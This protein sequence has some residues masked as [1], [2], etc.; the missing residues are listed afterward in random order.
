MIRDNTRSMCVEQNHLRSTIILVYLKI[1]ERSVINM[2]RARMLMKVLLLAIFLSPVVAQNGNVPVF[3]DSKWFVFKP[4]PSPSP[5]MYIGLAQNYCLNATTPLNCAMGVNPPPTFYDW[6][7]NTGWAADL[8]LLPTGARWIWAPNITPTTSPAA[9]EEFTFET[10][11]YVCD[12]PVGGTISLASDNSAEVSI[13]GTSIAGSSSTSADQLTTFSIPASVLLGS[14]ITLGARPNHIKV[15]A[16]N[17]SG[18][19]QDNYQC[20]P[21]AIVL[22]GKFEFMG[23][24][25]CNGFSGTFKTGAAETLASCPAGQSGSGTTRICVCGTWLPPT[26]I[27]MTAPPKCTGKNGQL[28]NVDAVETQSCPTGQIASPSSHRCQSNGT[29]DVPL[30]TCMTP[31]PP[32]TCAGA[33]GPFA[34][35]AMETIACPTGQVASPPRTHTCMANGQ[36]GPTTGGVCTL[37]TLGAGAM[38]AR[39]RGSVVIGNCPSGTSCGSRRSTAGNRSVWCAIFGIDCPVRLQ[40]TDWFCDPG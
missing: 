39:D 9:L 25:E 2:K 13:N 1:E 35:G 31:P 11:F 28:F 12:P 32:V 19:A 10:D 30:G 40:T 21:A 16:R 3:S 37:P 6:P 14:S 33:T 24:G 29:W 17:A 34:V 26:T 15:T 27:C 23:T 8:S 20:N 4:R 18:C 38:C 36:W 22:G 7:N 5:P